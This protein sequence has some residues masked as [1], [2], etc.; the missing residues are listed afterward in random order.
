MPTAAPVLDALGGE[1]GVWLVGGAVR[2]LLL[3]RT[4]RELDVVVEGDA[5]AVARRAAERLGGDGRGHDRFG[6]APVRARGTAFDVAA[7]RRESYPRPGALPDVRLGA[8]IEEDL[9]RRDFTVNPLALRLADGRLAGRP[10]TRDDLAAK[11]LRVLH[12]G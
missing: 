8:G 2:D 7:A 1:P 4:P 3:G 11:L 9:A 12:D 10:G 6:T 5:H